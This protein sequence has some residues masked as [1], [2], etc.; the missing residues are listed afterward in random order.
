MHRRQ[1]ALALALVALT[2]LLV[3]CGGGDSR[4]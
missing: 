2:L 1:I 3:A 4:Y